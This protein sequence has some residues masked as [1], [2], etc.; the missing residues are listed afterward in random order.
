M[1][2]RTLLVAAI[3]APAILGAQLTRSVPRGVHLYRVAG[4]YQGMAMDAWNEELELRDTTVAGESWYKLTQF[5]PRPLQNATF[6]YVAM[7][8]KSGAQT[9]RVHYE[10]R[11]RAVDDCEM[12]LAGGKITASITPPQLTATPAETKGDAFP[13]FAA[14]TILSLRTL[15]DGDTI[16]F[17]AFRCLP[18]FKEAAIK[19]FP[20]VG[21]VKSAEVP[22][23]VDAKPEPAWVIEGDAS[24]HM[25]VKIAKSDRQVLAFT[26]PEGSVGEQTL[27]YAATR[28][29]PVP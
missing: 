2:V 14:A 8:K 11:G 3:A 16:R 20:F 26:L 15:S 7:W 22:R 13:D 18:Y 6:T 25:V 5:T 17:T 12:S 4:S 10:N 9:A 29:L 28:T 1:R 23:V 21:V 19:T 27:S 24:Y